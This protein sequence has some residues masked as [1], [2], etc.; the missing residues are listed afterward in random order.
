M[1]IPDLIR[2]LEEAGISLWEDAGELRFRAPRGALTKSLRDAL[3]ES[4]TSVLECLRSRST[5]DPIESNPVEQFKPFPL[6]DIQAAYLFGRRNS[7]A[8]GGVGCHG[9]AEFVFP[10]LDPS[11]AESAWRALIGRHAAL[12]TVIDSDGTQRVLAQVPDYKI[13]VADLRSAPTSNWQAAVTQLR[14]EMDHRLYEPDQWPLFDLRITLT[15]VG[16]VLHFSLDL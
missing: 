2:D 12:R 7:F 6:T 10:S 5:K 9:Y 16:A 11:V 1:N 8:Y 13:R 14:R 3:R 4:K 15:P